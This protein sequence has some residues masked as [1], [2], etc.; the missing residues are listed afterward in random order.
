MKSRKKGIFITATGTDIG[1]TFVSALL[2]KYLRKQRIHAGYFKPVLSGAQ[3]K[4][5]VLIG[6]DVHY[7]CNTARLEKNAEDLVSYAFE[8]AVSPHL[9]AKLEDKTVKKEKI[10]DDFLR[11]SQ[12]FDYM[13]VEG[14]GGIV[15]PLR[16]DE[17]SLMLVDVIQMLKL[18]LMIV[19]S[20]GLGTI[21]TVVLTVDFAKKHNIPIQGI[22]LNHYE[23]GNYLHEDNRRQIE[24][25]TG[26]PVIALVQED[27]DE[28][29]FCIKFG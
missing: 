17:E 9:A 28:L 11:A 20:A 3:K 12:E 15:C 4:E 2:V 5:G 23:K 1:K 19:A 21:N 25:L 26:I 7:V 24:R 16:L 22:I 14:C 8:A 10:L 29:E 27:A 6:S 13:V 18:E